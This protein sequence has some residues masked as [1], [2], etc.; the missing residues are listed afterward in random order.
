M[1]LFGFLAQLQELSTKQSYV[2]TPQ[3]DCQGPSQSAPFSLKALP[4]SRWVSK[5]VRFSFLFL[6]KRLVSGNIIDTVHPDSIKEF[7]KVS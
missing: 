4:S 7:D 2:I 3:H 5:Q 6:G 1:Q